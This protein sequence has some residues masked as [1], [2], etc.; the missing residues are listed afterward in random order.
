MRA[1]I[2]KVS[3]QTTCMDYLLMELVTNDL[4]R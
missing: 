3:T 1:V 2:L 4:P